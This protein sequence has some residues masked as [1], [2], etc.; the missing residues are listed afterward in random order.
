MLL[1]T[2]K[3]NVFYEKLRA[4]QD[5]SL[6][7]DKGESVA[8]IGSNGAGKT[9][10]LN[11]IAGVLH[12]KSGS[13]IFKGTRIESMPPHRIVNLGIALVPE[14]KAIFPL[15]SVMDH[16][17]L[18]AQLPRAW[19]RRYDTLERVFQLFPRLKE[20]KNQKAGTLSGGESQML[21]V[22]RALM[23]RPELLLLD[24]PSLG[25]AP[26]LVLILFK[27]LRQLREEGITILLAEQHVHQALTLCDRA[28]VI[29]TGRVALEGSANELLRNEEIK[30]KYLGG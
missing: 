2:S 16:L 28:Y 12:P 29:E 11:T 8:L 17:L 18:G 24:E 26:K 27:T 14:A 13:I 7:I 21:N 20:R 15:M 25:L 30:K 6:E 4:L 22:A 3:I 23:S 19:D 5:V 9:T 1:F 10:T